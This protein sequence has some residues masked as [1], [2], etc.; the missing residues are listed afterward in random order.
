MT[1]QSTTNNQ[2]NQSNISPQ[3][4]IKIKTFDPIFVDLQLV[5]ADHYTVDAQVDTSIQTTELVYGVGVD[6]QMLQNILKKLNYLPISQVRSTVMDPN[7]VEPAFGIFDLSTNN[8]HLVSKQT[9][10]SSYSRYKDILVI[11]FADANVSIQ[12]KPNNSIQYGGADE[13]FVRLLALKLKQITDDEITLNKAW[14]DDD[15]DIWLH[16]V[17]PQTKGKPIR[18]WLPLAVSQMIQLLQKMSWTV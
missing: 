7:V 10:R 2:S 6:M 8:I 12:P 1:T 15:G 3:T 11:V 18:A 17:D 5:F 16:V 4:I 13:T 14:G 9:H